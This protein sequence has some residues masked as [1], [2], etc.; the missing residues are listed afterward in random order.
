MIENFFKKI[1]QGSI[2]KVNQLDMITEN[3]NKIRKEI[4]EFFSELE[5]WS[6]IMSNLGA[7]IKTDYDRNNFVEYDEIM[8]I[9]R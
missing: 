8:E 3:I 6:K 9:V 1:I 4:R 7:I 5:N 2:N